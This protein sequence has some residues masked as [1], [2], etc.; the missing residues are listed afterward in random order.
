MGLVHRRRILAVLAAGLICAPSHAGET[1]TVIEMAVFKS[2]TCGC[3]TKWVEYMQR[4]GFKI[5]V[6][7]Q[8]DLTAIKSYYGITQSLASCHTAV[9]DGYVIE[10][11]VPA[12][13]VRR[14][15]EERPAVRGLTAPGMPQFSPGM[16]SE[17]PR[18][19]DVLSFDAAGNVEVYSSY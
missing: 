15:F 3:C 14:L 4:N 2:P 6:Y 19:Y 17:T 7:D 1:S 11:H 16:R 9:V 10:G 12:A 5:D 18:D 13:D 8:S